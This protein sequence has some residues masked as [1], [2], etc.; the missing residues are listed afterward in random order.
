M[1]KRKATFS[2]RG[3]K[4][5]IAWAVILVAATIWVRAY[6]LIPPIVLASWIYIRT[7]TFVR[8]AQW[9]EA[10]TPVSRALL[11]WGLASLF[12]AGAT[13]YVVCFIAELGVY[14][15]PDH[16]RNGRD[17]GARLCLVSK[18]KYGVARNEESPDGY[19]RTHRVGAVS[20][21]DH[22]LTNTPEGVI[23]QRIV[24][25]PGDTVRIVDAALYVNSNGDADTRHAVATFCLNKRVAYADLCAMRLANEEL[26]DYAR[27]DT[28]P[29]GITFRDGHTAH[30]DTTA[31]R[32]PVARRQHEWA[33]QTF[34]PIVPNLYDARC[35]P[36]TPAYK[37][38]AYQ[39]GP[40]R[41]PRKGDVID[42][43]YANVKLYG[44]MVKEHEGVDIRPANG[45][46]YKFKMNY[47]MTL[48]D[49]RDV[50]CD[51]RAFGPLPE[52]KILSYVA[53]F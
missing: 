9:V 5:S 33:R 46:T 52:S 40:V 14:T 38:N 27:L 37:W 13:A 8:L 26:G 43:T 15:T 50:L 51:S 23:I 24:A 21:G 6:E 44:P 49:D 2:W 47:Y 17:D 12:A 4:Y 7:D 29:R 11:S 16:P 30:A 42:L 45:Q 1:V 39:W 10:H 48:S 53:F 18:L 22:A 28:L 36:H 31:T 25:K 41:L 3:S 34:A 19:Y 32:L 35:Y 20:N